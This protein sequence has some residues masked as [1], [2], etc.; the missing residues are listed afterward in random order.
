LPHVVRD[1]KALGGFYADRGLPEAAC[2]TT[3][4]R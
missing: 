1:R 4:L 3:L 2:C